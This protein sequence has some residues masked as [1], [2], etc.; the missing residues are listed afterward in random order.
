MYKT[1][2]DKGIQAIGFTNE[3]IRLLLTLHRLYKIKDKM[4][5]LENK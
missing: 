3:N 2:S 5:I 1:L 4:P